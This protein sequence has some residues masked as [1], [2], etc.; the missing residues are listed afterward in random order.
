MHPLLADFVTGADRP[1]SCNRRITT[2]AFVHGV[3][4][5]H[6]S[7]STGFRESSR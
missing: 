7:D 6:V 3:P 4:D 2:K 5:T 1:S